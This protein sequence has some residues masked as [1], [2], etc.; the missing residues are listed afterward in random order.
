MVLPNVLQFYDI[1]L[2]FD[3]L[4]YNFVVKEIQVQ[5]LRI[6]STKIEPL[7]VFEDKRR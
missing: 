7:P 1:Q 6:V 4:K 3:I 5:K 2:V